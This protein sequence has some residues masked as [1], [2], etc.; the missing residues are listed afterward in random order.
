M[1]YKNSMA[2]VSAVIIDQIIAVMKIIQLLY[3]CDFIELRTYG[4]MKG[5]V[6][7]R[8]KWVHRV[9]REKNNRPSYLT[10]AE[11]RD[12]KKALNLIAEAINCIEKLIN[13]C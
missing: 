5:I 1:S 9:K 4:K 7:E 12:I 3:L 8:N 13:D 11:P 6:G 2:S 10:H